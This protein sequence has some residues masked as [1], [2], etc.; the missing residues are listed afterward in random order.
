MHKETKE[1]EAPMP[2]TFEKGNEAGAFLNVSI[3]EDIQNNELQ[4]IEPA[5]PIKP[6]R[7]CCVTCLCVICCCDTSDFSATQISKLNEEEIEL[8]R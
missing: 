3:N 6:H 1:E 8:Y 2:A 7:N 4:N 5:A